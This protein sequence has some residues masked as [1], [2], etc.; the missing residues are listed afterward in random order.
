MCLIDNFQ[1]IKIG[2]NPTTSLPIAFGDVVINLDA[3]VVSIESR[4]GFLLKCNLDFDVCS[5]DVSGWYFGKLAG[6]LGTMNNEI[7]D[8]F[9]TST[10][11]IVQ[12]NIEMV[13]SWKLKDCEET[14]S[15]A[16]LP[17]LNDELI[18]LC[19]S[20]FKRKTSYFTTCFDTIE[21]FSFY[22]ICLS[23]SSSEKY[24]S[25]IKEMKKGAC[26]AAISYIE[27]CDSRKIPLRV[28]DVCIQ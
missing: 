4:K 5:L 24:K 12:D 23:L 2:S 10:N 18:A 11:E 20:F 6:I 25:S 9:S 7:H 13:N 8:D 26:T 15:V 17:P 27:A 1:K 21:P 16:P 14:K 3:N 22:Q 19:D 28:P